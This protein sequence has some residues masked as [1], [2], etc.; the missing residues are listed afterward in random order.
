LDAGSLICQRIATHQ[1]NCPKARKGSQRIIRLASWREY[2]A[3]A[4]TPSIYH[5]ITHDAAKYLDKPSEEELWV[6]ADCSDVA[7][8]RMPV[9]FLSHASSCIGWKKKGLV[10]DIERWACWDYPWTTRNP[11]SRLFIARHQDL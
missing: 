10:Q 9:N 8:N 11:V 7:A 4:S 5:P 3:S 2:K 1:R 6:V